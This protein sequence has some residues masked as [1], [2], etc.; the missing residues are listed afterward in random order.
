MIDH[1]S[2]SAARAT[3]PGAAMHD[4]PGGLFLPDPPHPGDY[5]MDRGEES[6]LI[7]IQCGELRCDRMVQHGTA[8]YFR[9]ESQVF[10]YVEDEGLAVV[11]RVSSLETAAALLGAL[12]ALE[13]G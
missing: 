4:G 9:Y 1:A 8:R 2:S 5:T 13:V 3:R 10:G 12:R 6:A 7:S 11:F